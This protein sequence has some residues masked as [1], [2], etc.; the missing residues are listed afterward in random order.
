[1][2]R[3]YENTTDATSLHAK[4]FIE[5]VRNRTTYN[6]DIEVGHRATTV[7]L[8]GNIAMKTGQ[9][10][11][12]DGKKETTNSAEANKM[13]RRQARRPWDLLRLTAGGLAYFSAFSFRV[14]PA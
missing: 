12:W 11:K 4:R 10:L 7:A 13:L 6:A 3:R 14:R 1:M 2:K 5:A 9:K 8:L